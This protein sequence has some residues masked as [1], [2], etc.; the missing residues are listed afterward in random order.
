M[1]MATPSREDY[2]EAIWRLTQEKGYA[3]VSDIAERL[4][5]APASVSRMVRRLTEE[6]VLTHE[7]YRGLALTPEGRRR[8]RLLLARHRLLERFLGLLG[9]TD[10][11]SIYRTVEGIEHHLGPDALAVIEQLLRYSEQ[12]PEWWQAFRA[13]QAAASDSAPPDP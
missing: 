13:W 6:G 12:H 10:R 3:R 5:L 8:G 9:M 2:I 1:P 4:G 7:R 11:Q